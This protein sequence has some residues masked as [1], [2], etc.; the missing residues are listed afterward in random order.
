M[1]TMYSKVTQCPRENQKI[2]ECTGLSI[3]LHA[4]AW[5]LIPKDPSVFSFILFEFFVGFGFTP[6][7]VTYT[8][9]AST[10]VNC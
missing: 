6:H 8:N 3:S 4:K 7:P 1:M 10:L 5:C 2:I 9:S